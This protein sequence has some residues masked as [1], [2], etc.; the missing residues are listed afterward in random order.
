MKKIFFI[1]S[2]FSKGGGAESLLTTIVN[3][4]NPNKYEIGI[5]EIEHD[6]IKTEPVNKNIKIY[7]Y[8]VKSSDPE[9]KSKMYSIYHEWDKIIAEYVP[10]DYDL[11]ISFNFLKPSFLLPLGKKNI[12]WIHSD[13]YNLGQT[14]KAEEYELQNEAFCKANTIVSISDITTQSLEELFPEHKHK[15]RVIYNGLDIEKIREKSKEKTEIKLK[16]PSILSIG[17]LDKRKNPIRLFHIFEQIHKKNLKIHLYYLGYGD[18]AESVL[19]IANKRG[20]SDYVHLLG[21][22]NNPF[23]IIAQ[24]D[25][26]GMFSLSEG[27]PMALLEGVAL[28]KP[29]VTS[30]IGGSRILANEQRCGKTVKTDEEAVKGILEFLQTERKSIERECRKSIQRFELKAYIDQ[31]EKL[32]DDVLRG[33]K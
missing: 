7:P 30:I 14:D 24:C 19:D 12:A 4:L 21:Y 26:I 8:Y 1:I 33:E 20:L 11:Y 22:F 5:M 18:L 31:I 3:N 27:F 16:H 10:L 32:F 17:R 13:V 9:R 29:F 15:I 23:P 2:S 6:E 25:V 28:D